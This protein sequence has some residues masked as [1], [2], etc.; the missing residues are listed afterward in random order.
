[1]SHDAGSHSH[2]LGGGGMRD[3]VAGV[4]VG[5]R[6]GNDGQSFYN[7]ANE[8]DTRTRP[9]K[10][11]AAAMRLI[12]VK[13]NGMAAS[14][15]GSD[16]VHAALPAPGGDG[17]RGTSVASSVQGGGVDRGSALASVDTSGNVYADYAKVEAITTEA[18]EAALNEIPEE[19]G[20]DAANP[21]A[22]FQAAFQTRV[23]REQLVEQVRGTESP[24]PIQF[25]TAKCTYGYIVRRLSYE[26]SSVS[27]RLSLSLVAPPVARRC[28]NHAY[29][30]ST[31]QLPRK[32]KT[33][34]SLARE[35]MN[36]ACAV[37]ADGWDDQMC[38]EG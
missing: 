26:F 7:V 33:C 38:M 28:T 15:G 31:A 5:V 2:S 37:R 34:L 22:A 32:N 19:T 4:G 21:M 35:R 9:E 16:T 36:G 10:A 20:E 3:A 1:M 27:F 24:S 29:T 13:A 25:H 18:V 14:G 6:G 17:G 11:L 30:P 12:A 8:I 23:M